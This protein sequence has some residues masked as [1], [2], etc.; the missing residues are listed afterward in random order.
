MKNALQFDLNEIVSKEINEKID[1]LENELE[2]EKNKNLK[3]N[4]E[5]YVLNN[6]LKES[7][8]I[9]N[10]L[11]Y[12]RTEF[13]KIK[14]S[15]SDKNGWYDSKQKNQFLYI[16][17]ILLD[18]FNI[19]KESNGWTCN[20]N[21][22][23][24]CTHLAINYYSKKEIVIDLLKIIMNDCTKEISF[25]KSFKMPYDY[26]KDEV[27]KFVSNP[28]FNT[29]GA[30]FGISDLWI[31]Y[32]ANEKNM[33][34]DLIMKNNYILE[35]DVFNKLLETIKQQKSNYHYLFAI[36]KYNNNITDEQIIKLG[37]L[38][39]NIPESVLNYDN[40]EHFIKNNLYKFNKKTLD[41]LYSKVSDDNQYKTLYWQ[42]FPVEYQ[43]KYL[44]SKDLE[45]ILKL[46]T[47]YRCK[48]NL[49]EKQSFIIDWSKINKTIN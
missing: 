43:Q 16:E 14:Q 47:D 27:I 30:I 28:Q 36:T 31:E 45:Q 37:E 49:E 40:L 13:S 35:D 21:D 24:L 5:I 11:D 20:R 10:L 44:L 6:K 32:G 1:S 48:W 33:P 3:Q 12:L 25:I 2:L 22:G 9:L 41:Y 4:Q 8:N 46:L 38:L 7:K 15:E 23:N 29:N 42:N 39:I 18:I 17:K 34:Y 19:E 26:S